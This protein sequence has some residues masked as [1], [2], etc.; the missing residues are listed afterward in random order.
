MTVKQISSPRQKTSPT[1]RWMLR[2]LL[3]LGLAWTCAHLITIGSPQWGPGARHD[4][5][6]FGQMIA[7]AAFPVLLLIAFGTQ[8]PLHGALIAG[9]ACILAALGLLFHA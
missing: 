3:A 2:G 9:T 6:V 1:S 5:V 8:K 4:S 7:I